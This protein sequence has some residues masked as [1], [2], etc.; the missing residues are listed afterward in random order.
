MKEE[1]HNRAQSGGIALTLRA[2]RQEDEK[3][4]FDVYASTRTEELSQTGWDAVQKE[5]FLLMQFAAQQQHYRSRFPEG[6][7]QIIVKDGRSIGR[8]YTARI[9]QE[10]RIL[11]IALLPEHRDAGIGTILLKD[12]LAEAEESRLAVRIYVESFNRSMR[13]FERLGFSSIETS[14]PNQLMEWRPKK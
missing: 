9:E 11:D 6:V 7:H 3:F 4:L 12:I 8:I 5:A 14:G 2:V 13:L 1:S 10:I